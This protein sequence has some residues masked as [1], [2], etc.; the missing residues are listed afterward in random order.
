MFGR[1]KSQLGPYK[2][3]RPEDRLVLAALVNAGA[4]LSQPRH[5]LHFVYEFADEASALSAA[6]AVPMWQS[7]VNPPVEGHNTWTVT[8]ERRDYVL[9][10]ENVAEDA[11]LFLA[12]AQ[13][14][15]GNYDG[16]E[17]SV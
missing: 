14:H 1:K 16:W 7:T 4:D 9:T 12:A 6:G 13:A 11:E 15:G 5:V 10:P 17:A 8:F 3:A 2:G